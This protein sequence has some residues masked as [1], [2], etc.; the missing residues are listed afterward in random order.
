MELSTSIWVTQLLAQTTEA[1][2]TDL[3]FEPV[4]AL[5][6]FTDLSS[7]LHFEIGSVLI[8]FLMNEA[9]VVK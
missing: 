4:M 3:Y 6:A 1:T 5:R 9:K 2:L 8:P 7:Q